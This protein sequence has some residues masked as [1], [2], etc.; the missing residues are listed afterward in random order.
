M[1]NT[2]VRTTHCSIYV[3][4]CHAL[5]CDKV[6]LVVF[7]LTCQQGVNVRTPRL[8]FHLHSPSC[9]PDTCAF[10]H[11][12]CKICKVL[13]CCRMIMAGGARLL[14]VG[15]LLVTAKGKMTFPSLFIL[16]RHQEECRSSCSIPA[17]RS[18]PVSSS[19]PLQRLSLCSGRG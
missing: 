15:L 7:L 11:I 8:L 9:L 6:R 4:L 16:G 3:V 18:D 19:L 5:S 1:F 13:N 10:H 17:G 12:W 14:P 2:A